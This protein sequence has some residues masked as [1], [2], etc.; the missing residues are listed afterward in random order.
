[1]TKWLAAAGALLLAMACVQAA[2]AGQPGAIRPVH[3]YSIVARDPDTG[4][5]GVAVQSH[6]FAVGSLVPWA[7]AGVGAVATQSFVETRYGHAGLD[8]MRSGLDARHALD[9][10]LAADEHA[11]VRQ[12]A[13]IDASGVTAVHTGEHCIRHAGHLAGENFTVQANLMQ[14]AGVPEVMASAFRGAQGSLAERMLAAL[15]AAQAVG[16]DLRGKQSAAILV[17]AAEATGQPLQDRLVDLHVEDHPEPLLEL[18][19]LLVLQ[20]AYEFMNRGDH[21]LERDDIDAAVEYYGRAEALFPENLEMKFWHAVSLLNAGR[22]EAAMPVLQQ[23]V[24]VE[25]AWRELLSRLVAA[26]LL[27]VDEQVLARIGKPVLQTQEAE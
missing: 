8:L 9:A 18:R 15:D 23:I 3:T 2:V 13:M 26:Q 22:T 16:G 10:L 27:T 17:V 20:T 12:V 6:W 14:N 19:R 25:P 21:A 5:I 7:E 24:G 1:M 4:Q 11:D